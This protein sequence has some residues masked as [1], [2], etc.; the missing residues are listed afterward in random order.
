M[1][2]SLAN[3][4]RNR[5]EPEHHVLEAESISRDEYQGTFLKINYR[6]PR[7]WV[8]YMILLQFSIEGSKTTFSS[9]LWNMDGCDFSLV[10]NQVTVQE[11]IPRYFKTEPDSG[12]HNNNNNNKA[13][14]NSW[15]NRNCVHS[16]K[17]YIDKR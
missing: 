6:G 2:Q 14:L 5:T 11:D 1:P 9:V 13:L 4:D 12:S 16:D 8:L 15:T 10:V 17:K 3:G 7:K